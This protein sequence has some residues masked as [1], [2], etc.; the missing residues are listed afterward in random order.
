MSKLTSKGFTLIEML[1]V[2]LIIGILAAIALPQYRKTVEKAKVSEALMN[3][4]AIEDTMHRYILVNGF[5]SERTFFK[6]FADIDLFNNEWAEEDYYRG[7]DF[8]YWALCTTEGCGIEVYRKQEYALI[9]FIN[10]DGAISHSCATQINDKGRFMC[11]Y[12]E[13][14]GWEYYEGEI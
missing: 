2:V 14:L 4:K 10:S 9:V 6:D 11:Q 8:D 7:K 3:I 5:P 1:V 12:L 13:S